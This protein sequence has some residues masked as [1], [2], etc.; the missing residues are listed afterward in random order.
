MVFI[1]RLER[2]AKTSQVTTDEKISL[3]DS[4]PSG[5]ERVG[6]PNEPDTDLYQHERQV[7]AECENSRLSASEAERVRM[8]RPLFPG[9]LRGD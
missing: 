5:D 6:I 3:A 8:F 1:S 7:D 2:P 4:I 9:D